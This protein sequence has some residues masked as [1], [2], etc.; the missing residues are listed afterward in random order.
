MK[1]TNWG[2]TEYQYWQ[3]IADAIDEIQSAVEDAP[4]GLLV[5]EFDEEVVSANSH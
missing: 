1:R 3:A 5:D 2:V 4:V